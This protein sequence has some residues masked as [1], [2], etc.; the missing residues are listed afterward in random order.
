MR[1][2]TLAILLLLLSAC[3][4]ATLYN[5][6]AREY[7]VEQGVSDTVIERLIMQ[8]A[9][10][11]DVIDVLSEYDNSSV[12]H[13][14]AANPGASLQVLEKLARHED[15]E[16]RLGVAENPNTPLELLLELRTPG[17]YSVIN[18]ALARHPNLPPELLQEMYLQRESLLSS[19]AK[20]PHTPPDILRAIARDGEDLDRIWLAGN[21]NLPEDVA[22]QLARSSSRVVRARLQ[23]RH[24]KD[25]DAALA[26]Q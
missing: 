19:F 11:S 23:N 13:L 8:A 26:A 24:L 12:L 9:L 18:T 14:V 1:A 16:V 5:M 25:S 6:H 10:E 17:H 3:D 15:M 4:D 20:N 7:L 21:P 22:Q 2:A